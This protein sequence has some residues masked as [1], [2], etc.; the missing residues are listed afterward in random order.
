MV[1]PRDLEV[2]ILP[3]DCHSLAHNEVAGLLA[4]FKVLHKQ[5]WTETHE[6]EQAD[7][8]NYFEYIGYEGE[9]DLNVATVIFV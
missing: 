3:L 2:A 1:A 9:Q 4:A 6:L 7:C 8:F 5:D